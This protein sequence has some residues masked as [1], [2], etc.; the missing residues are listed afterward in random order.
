MKTLRIHPDD[1]VEVIIEGSADF[2]AGHKILCQDLHAGDN[3]VKYGYPI[4]HLTEDRK[5]GSLVDHRHIATNLSGTL[6]YTYAPSPLSSLELPLNSPSTPLSMDSSLFGI[7]GFLG[8]LVRLG[9]GGF[10]S[11]GVGFRF[12]GPVVLG[13]VAATRLLPFGGS[14]CGL[15]ACV[16]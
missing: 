4:G 16:L 3:I 12:L 8:G 15:C 14:R 2:P 1:N 10:R 7:G 6:D 11:R 13:A 5:A 9:G